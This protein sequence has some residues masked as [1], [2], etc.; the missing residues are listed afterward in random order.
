MSNL[1]NI[2]QSIHM[3]GSR[4]VDEL[5]CWRMMQQKALSGAKNLGSL[6]EIQEW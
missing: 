6:D 3:V 1:V 5:L 4:I 2:Q